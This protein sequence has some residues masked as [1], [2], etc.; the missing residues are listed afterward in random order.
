MSF[1]EEF[2]Q[3]A[4]SEFLF[5]HGLDRNR[6]KLRV[7]CSPSDALP[8]LRDLQLQDRRKVLIP[9]YVRA[10]IVG[11]EAPCTHLAA[12]DSGGGKD[13]LVVYQLLKNADV[14]CAWV[15]VGDRPQEYEKSWRL[16]EIVRMTESRM[17]AELPFRLEH[18]MSDPVWESQVAGNKYEPCG[19]PWVAL[20]AFD[21]V[22]A[23]V[24]GGFPFF[25]V[26]NERSANYGNDV[27][28]EGRI[29]NHQYDKS[30][31]FDQRVHEYIREFFVEDLHYFSVL[32]H[33]WEVQIART[34]VSRSLAAP[35]IED[36]NFLRVFLSC[37]E[38]IDG[39]KW[40]CKC[41]KCAFVFLLLSA[42]CDQDELVAAFGEN[43]FN[44]QSL[45]P[46]FN[47]LLTSDTGMKP[48]ECVGI[49]SEA[50]LSLHLAVERFGMT[51]FIASVSTRKCSSKDTRCARF[52]KT[53]TRNTWCRPSSCRRCESP[54]QTTLDTKHEAKLRRLFL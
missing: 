44:N 31:H 18:E 7:C 20:A 24:A 12:H 29:V 41:A 27:E 54:L 21:S 25:A 51:E 4:L 2:Y 28:H 38:A 40:C 53:T 22:L 52:S 50:L 47:A 8:A 15:H 48:M 34:F 1:W 11:F 14:P 3:D 35:E 6:L 30:F 49:A 45:F 5:R 33:L 46:E 42:W 10:S 36:N 32:Q 26:G 19:H 16:K 17:Q 13:S 43:L 23:A 39:D 37:N 9:L